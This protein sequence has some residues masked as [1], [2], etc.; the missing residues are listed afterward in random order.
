MAVDKQFWMFEQEEL[1][2]ILFP[3]IL[4]AALSAAEDA[5]IGLGASYGVGVDWGLVNQTVRQWVSRYTFDLVTRVTDTSARFLQQAIAD[6]I[7][8]GQ[9][10]K[11]LVKQIAP[12]FGPVRAKMIAATEVTRAY[13]EG[14][15]QAWKQ[16]GL[17]NGV[18]WMTGRDEIVCPVCGE[19]DGKIVGIDKW[20]SPTV[21]Q[22]P[23][24]I[25]CRCWLQP[26]VGSGSEA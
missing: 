22:P 8:T 18:R 4:G 12:M 13:A 6:W 26:V 25:N 1:F 14:N 5:A 9:P 7:Q 23:A 2:R 24:H 19:L 17:V 20:F 10:L 16:S 15:R 21:Q 3:E 11:D